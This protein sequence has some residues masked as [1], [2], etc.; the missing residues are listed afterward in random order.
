MTRKLQVDAIFPIAWIKYRTT[1]GVIISHVHAS[2]V[3]FCKEIFQTGNDFVYTSLFYV[4][5]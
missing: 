5:L 2:K 3:F 4:F 1:M